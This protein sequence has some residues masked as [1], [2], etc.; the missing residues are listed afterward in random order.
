M[1]IRLT[2]YVVSAR[3]SLRKKRP[4][5]VRA[6]PLHGGNVRKKP[7]GP[8][9]ADISGNNLDEK[10]QRVRLKGLANLGNTC[11][12]NSVVQ[13]MLHPYPASY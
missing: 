13:V 4:L 10:L 12:F 3:R 7:R 9:F 11:Y 5:S 2:C 8:V 1:A 6:I